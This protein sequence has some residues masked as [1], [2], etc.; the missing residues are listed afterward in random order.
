MALPGLQPDGSGRGKPPLDISPARTSS[1]TGDS[2]EAD[3]IE[4]HSTVN[5][6]LYGLDSIMAVQMLFMNF[7][8]G[9][10]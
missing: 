7:K 4:D 8:Q 10:R 3:D 1:E 6:T 5:V 2:E 9:C